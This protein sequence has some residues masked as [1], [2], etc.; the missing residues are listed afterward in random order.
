[1]APARVIAADTLP[2]DSTDPILSLGWGAD[3]LH[4]VRFNQT[5]TNVLAS[6]GSDR[7]IVLYDVRAGKPLT[8]L[9]LAMRTN[10]IA[11]NP[12][13]A[14][15]FTA[16]RA[17]SGVFTLPER[18]LTMRSCRRTRTTTAIHSTCARWSRP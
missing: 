9:T 5:E 18:P 17:P 10:A 3:S 7:T 4:T 1:M 2:P 15:H 13:E 11:W 12:M 14:F 16:V 6:C 8:K